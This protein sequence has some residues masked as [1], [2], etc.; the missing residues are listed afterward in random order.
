MKLIKAL[1]NIAVYVANSI[2]DFIGGPFDRLAAEKDPELRKQALFSVVLRVLWFMSYAFGFGGL[3]FSIASTLLTISMWLTIMT[4]VCNIIDYI[5]GG[6][7]TAI[8]AAA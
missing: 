4:V 7:E 3:L 2:Y 5:A 8:A 1:F 6:K